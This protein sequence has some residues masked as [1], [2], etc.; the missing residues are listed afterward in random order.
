MAN[1]IKGDIKTLTEVIGK[2]LILS[3]LLQKVE[4]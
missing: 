3:E 4:M 1:L 2:I